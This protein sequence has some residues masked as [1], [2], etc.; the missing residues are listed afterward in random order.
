MFGC[1]RYSNVRIS[2]EVYCYRLKSLMYQLS[3]VGVSISH[4]ELHCPLLYLSLHYVDHIIPCISLTHDFIK[5][6]LSPTGLSD[7]ESLARPCSRVHVLCTRPCPLHRSSRYSGPA[8]F[9]V[10][11]HTTRIL[12]QL[13]KF[14]SRFPQTLS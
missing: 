10:T 1:L 6:S 4:G 14:S 11:F 8:V 12:N 9:L 13:A 2:K 3:S 7:C 5:V